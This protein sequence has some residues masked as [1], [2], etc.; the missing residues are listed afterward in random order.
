MKRR[1]ATLMIAA[2]L[3]LV[4]SGFAEHAQ[5]AEARKAP[6][7]DRVV[8]MYFHRTQRCPTCLK[9]GRYTEEAI[10]AGFAKQLKDRTVEFYYIDFQDEKNA[11]FAKAYNITGP[12]LVVA[13]VADGK[14]AEFR[15]LKDIWTEVNDKKA[16]FKYVQS[17]IK[18]YREKGGAE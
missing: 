7:K 17:Q 12:A 5:A 10:K 4:F 8:A 18:R 1:N 9:M 11:A 13:K 3:A 14:V 2:A 6:P 15:N 16:F